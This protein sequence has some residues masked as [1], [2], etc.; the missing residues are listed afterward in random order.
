MSRTLSMV[1]NGVLV[2]MSPAAWLMLAL[3]AGDSKG[4]AARGL[5]SLKYFTVLSNLL[6]CLASLAYLVWCLT[7]GSPAPPW[8][9]AI[10]LMAAAAVMLTFLTVIVLLGPVLGWKKMYASGNL[11]MHLILPLLAAVDCVLFAPVGTLPFAAT[12]VAAIPCA[13]YA[14]WY[15]G[16]VVRNGAEKDGVVY[17]FYGFLRWGWSKVPLV[18]ASMITV[19][20]LLGL[21]LWWGNQ[22][23]GSL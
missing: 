15:L 5:E 21:V 18:T 1:I 23:L 19:S 22:M 13:L 9:L 17:D 10:K 8:L 2:V 20:W 14:V 7:A 11:W 3:G 4:L 16:M 12:F 6:S